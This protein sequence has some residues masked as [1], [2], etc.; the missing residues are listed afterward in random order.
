MGAGTSGAGGRPG[1]PHA[2]PSLHAR[3][4][5]RTCPLRWAAAVVG[6]HAVHTGSSVLAVVPGTVVHVLLTVLAGEACG[7][8]SRGPSQARPAALASSWLDPQH[9]RVGCCP[10]VACPG[11]PAVLGPLGSRPCPLFSVGPG[12]TFQCPRVTCSSLNDHLAQGLLNRQGLGNAGLWRL[13]PGNSP[14]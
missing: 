10:S 12:P 4:G 11:V 8:R 5:G 3:P 14:V 7:G 1:L 6:V 2:T 9:P 13:V